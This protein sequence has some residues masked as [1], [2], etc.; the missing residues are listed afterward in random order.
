MHPSVI[1]H[2][3]CGILGGQAL[4]CL[5][6]AAAI[7]AA[8]HSC[9]ACPG[10]TA[11]PALRIHHG[12]G[13]VC[14]VQQSFSCCWQAD[15]GRSTRQLDM[16]VGWALRWGAPGSRSIGGG[17]PARD[18]SGGCNADELAER[19]ACSAVGQGV[20][21]ARLRPLFPHPRLI[22]H[23]SDTMAVKLGINGGWGGGVWR[24]PWPSGGLWA[25]HSLSA[26]APP[27]PGPC[28]LWPHRPPG[29]RGDLEPGTSG[30]GVL[31]P[32][33]RP[34]ACGSPPS[35]TV[36]RAAPPSSGFTFSITLPMQ[37]C[38]AACERDDVDVVGEC[39]VG[40]AA[41]RHG[42]RPWRSAGAAGGEQG[43]GWGL[44][45]LLQ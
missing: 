14:D 9:W 39:A 33:A 35:G 11:H 21:H 27:C 12:S 37:V 40:R 43:R 10:A 18:A 32:L 4:P 13:S 6:G 41:P 42:R 31:G 23:S 38:R 8:L 34:Q 20:R 25:C 7:S 17:G 26:S 30:D 22:S 2:Q 29:A 3:S 16:G 1:T 5:A 19:E 15:A 44:V 36:P 24:A 28:R 45:H